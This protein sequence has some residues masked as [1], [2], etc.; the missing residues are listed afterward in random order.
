MYLFTESSR[1]AWLITTKFDERDGERGK[2]EQWDL[3]VRERNLDEHQRNNS[4]MGFFLS[5][6]QY[7]WAQAFSSCSEQE[8]LF[9]GIHGPV[10]ALLLLQSMGRVAAACGLSS[11]DAQRLAAPQHV[12]SL[13]RAR[14]EPLSPTLA[15]RFSTTDHQGSTCPPWQF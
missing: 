4:C 7:R 5:F 9:A 12:G 15:G 3:V 2:S 1:F 8:L 10:A 14:A 13:P 6:T 11:C